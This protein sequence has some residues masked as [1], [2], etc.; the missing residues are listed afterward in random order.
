MVNEH[1]WS[2]FPKQG[3]LWEEGMQVQSSEDR[4]VAVAIETLSGGAG[5]LHGSLRLPLSL[6]LESG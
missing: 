2:I 1:E 4:E 3:A 5:A 6:A